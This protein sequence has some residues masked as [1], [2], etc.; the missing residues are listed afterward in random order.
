MLPFFQNELVC[1]LDRV[2]M[3]PFF[4]YM[5]EGESVCVSRCDTLRI[6][7]FSKRA[8]A[9][10]AWTFGM[11]RF[12]QKSKPAEQQ[13][14]TFSRQWILS[15]GD[16]LAAFS[17]FLSETPYDTELKKDNGKAF[18]NCY[19]DEEAHERERGGSRLRKHTRRLWR[20]CVNSTR[21]GP[22]SSHT[23]AEKPI[24]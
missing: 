10:V 20:R 17:R 12:V 6:C 9:L 13:D 8:G 22:I 18:E 11:D 4:Q 5:L 16:R 2:G 7:T 3:L 1:L 14:G 15:S 21:K 24:L 19:E 23:F